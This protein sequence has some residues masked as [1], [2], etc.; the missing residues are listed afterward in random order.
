[1]TEIKDTVSKL[2]ETLKDGEGG[3]R[4]AAEKIQKPECFSS[5]NPALIQPCR[6]RAGQSRCTSPT[7]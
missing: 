6:S 7:I 4:Q 2:I 1:M 5:S 3:Y